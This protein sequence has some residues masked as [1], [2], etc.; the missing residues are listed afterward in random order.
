MHILFHLK[1]YSKSVATLPD[2]SLVRLLCHKHTACQ[3]LL[4]NFFSLREKKQALDMPPCVHGMT[5]PPRNSFGE[6]KKQAGSLHVNRAEN[7]IPCSPRSI[8]TR[9]PRLFEYKREKTGRPQS[10]YADGV[11]SHR[12]FYRRRNTYRPIYA[13]KCFCGRARYRC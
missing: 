11:C 1:I 7:F 8:Y 9:T 2:E 3:G 4:R 13:A 6:R 10:S 5:F 12:Q